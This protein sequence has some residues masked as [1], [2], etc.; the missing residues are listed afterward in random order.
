MNSECESVHQVPFLWVNYT[1]NNEKWLVPWTGKKEEVHLEPETS[2][3][4]SQRRETRCAQFWGR[5]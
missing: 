1:V 5:G 4:C 2:R 3:K